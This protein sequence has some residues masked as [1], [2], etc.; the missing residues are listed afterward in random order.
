MKIVLKYQEPETRLACYMF[1]E[2]FD[3][4]AEQDEAAEA[5]N[6]VKNAG[7]EITFFRFV[8]ED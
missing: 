2:V 4:P 7:Y 6:A 8:E 1:E 5:Y 3:Y